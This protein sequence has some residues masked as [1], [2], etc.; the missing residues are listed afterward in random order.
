[1]RGRGMMIY[2]PYGLGASVHAHGADTRV[3]IIIIVV[4]MVV[5]VYSRNGSSPKS[6]SSVTPL[7]LIFSQPARNP[8]NGD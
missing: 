6:S 3:I 7:L 8:G 4:V 1:M 2:E 5:K